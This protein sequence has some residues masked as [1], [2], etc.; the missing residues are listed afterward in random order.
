MLMM[1][2]LLKLVLFLITGASS[3]VIPESGSTF[4]HKVKTRDVKLCVLDEFITTSIFGAAVYFTVTNADQYDAEVRA[5]FKVKAEELAIE[6][7]VVEDLNEVVEEA[8]KEVEDVAKEVEEEATTEVE[9]DIED[10][11]KMTSKVAV[12]SEIDVSLKKSVASTVVGEKQKQDRLKASESKGSTKENTP[13][14]QKVEQTKQKEQLSDTTSTTS[15]A[16]KA[17]FGKKAIVKA[18]MPW[19]KF[20]SIE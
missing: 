18:F 19:K 2:T 9:K 5:E 12:T 13:S 3:F 15:T 20:S 17:G 16:G 11:P 14:E 8:A 6:S 4:L 7:E 1:N 10:P